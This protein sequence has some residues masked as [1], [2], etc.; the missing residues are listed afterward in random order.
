MSQHEA[1]ITALPSERQVAMLRQR[2]HQ[3][4]RRLRNLVEVAKLND[5]LVG[6]I[7][8]FAVQLIAA[9]SPREILERLETTLREKFAAE[10]AAIVIYKDSLVAS[11]A[12]DRFAL[13]FD[14]ND[15]AL[16]P[17]ATFLAAA[18][19]RCGRL[20][21]R[22]KSVLF[23]DDDEALGSAAMVPLGE[24]A[25]LGFL[26]IGNSSED[27]FNP[28]KSTDFLDHLGA[29]VAVALEVSAAGAQAQ[30]P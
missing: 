21:Q 5:A 4:E 16:K 29:L 7:H 27:Y 14:R 2:N 1:R 10:R 11:A 23:G 3:L 9:R 8:D 24:G 12:D 26:V 28:G 6:K 18:K 13:A 22:Q 17:F 30:H 19:T 25:R 20:R 15:D